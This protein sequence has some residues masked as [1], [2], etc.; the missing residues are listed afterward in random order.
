MNIKSE[1]L[2]HRLSKLLFGTYLVLLIWVIL[3][4]CNIFE[5]VISAYS[6]MRFITV[7]ERITL[8][9]IPFMGYFDPEFLFDFNK[10][11]DAVLNVLV[12]FPLGLYASYFA[13]KRKFLSATLIAFACSFAFEVIQLF[14]LL[15][16]FDPED[17]ITNTFGAVV[18]YGL[19]RLIYRKN[20]G[21]L[22]IAALNVAT[23]LFL[24][25]LIPLAAFATVNTALNFDLYIG[26]LTR[27][28]QI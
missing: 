23:I 13:K 1:A 10:I 25:V 17:F 28:L 18:G 2:L 4:K 11:S 21:D 26:I 24:A 27:E 9:G 6:F 20:N 7:Y 8:F 16:A 19:Y 12:F 5:S 22:R 14:S 3:F 15:G